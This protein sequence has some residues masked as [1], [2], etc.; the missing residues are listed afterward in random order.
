MTNLNG[1]LIKCPHCNFITGWR[2]RALMHILNEH[3]G[4]EKPKCPFCGYLP[5]NIE[6]AINHFNN[7]HKTK[8]MKDLIEIKLNTFEKYDKEN[9]KKDLRILNHNWYECPLCFF[10]AE[11]KSVMTKHFDEHILKEKYNSHSLSQ[12]TEININGKEQLKIFYKCPFDDRRYDKS[13]YLKNHLAHVHDI[14]EDFI[15]SDFEISIRK[16]K[17]TLF[18]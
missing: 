14:H 16:L 9:L 6:D 8:N 2:K 7:N 18:G 1:N 12:K 11:D 17:I 10:I 4:L 3:I 5:E 13:I 15:A